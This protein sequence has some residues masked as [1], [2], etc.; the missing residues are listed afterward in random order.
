MPLISFIIPVY[1]VEGYLPECIESLQKQHHQEIEII[2]VDDGSTDTSPRICDQYALSDER[3]RVIHQ[4]NRGVSHA[5]NV[6]I[7]AA[8]G[9]YLTFVDSDDWV[10]PDYVRLL[11]DVF[12]EHPQ[13][14]ISMCELCRVENGIE[15]IQNTFTEKRIYSKEAAISLLC[16]DKEL[17]NYTC[18]KLYRRALFATIR[19]P[20]DRSICEDMAILYQL[21]YL[22]KEIVHI[23]APAYYYRAREG[24]SLSSQRT[25]EKDYPY[26]LSGYEMALFIREKN[27]FPERRLSFERTILSRG[28]HLLHRCFRTSNPKSYT[29]IIE[30]TL[31]KIHSFDNWGWVDI[32]LTNYL[33][34]KLLYTSFPMYSGLY[35]FFRNRK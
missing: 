27:L 30:D 12:G 34:R 23:P 17:K 2:L 3:I 5:R 24:S 21:F 22:A 26:F 4:A 6:G 14:C 16:E 9:E 15:T 10:S 33:R 11:V 13:A 18:A 28:I 7:E 35:H 25:P 20:E 32:G 19:F 29:Y 8:K 1:N 31:S